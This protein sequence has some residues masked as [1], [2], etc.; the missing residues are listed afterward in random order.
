MKRVQEKIKDLVDAR[1]YE[2]VKNYAADAE[3]TVAAYRFTDATAD[4]LAKW[5]DEIGRLAHSNST[6]A[7]F[8][9]AGN[10]GAGK[11]HLLAV[12][13]AVTEN[14]DLRARLADSHVAASA[15]SLPRRRLK[16][17]R[18]ERGTAPTFSEEF[19][20]ALTKTFGA[21]VDNFGANPAQMLIAAVQ[22]PEAEPLV[23]IVDS[24]QTRLA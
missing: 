6:G 12:L 23:L 24:A 8:A 2:A 20:N 1:P 22:Q 19:R 11:S 9:L 16:V 7:A 3:Q 4:L 14:P 15:Q 18:V 13:A 10:R 21:A 17:V 5:F